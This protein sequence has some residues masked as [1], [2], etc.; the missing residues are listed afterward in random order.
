MQLIYV[1]ILMW[2]KNALVKKKKDN[3]SFWKWKM[4][5]WLV[6]KIFFLL[7]I[8][9]L[10]NQTQIINITFKFLSYSIV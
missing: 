9:H 3:L 1:F 10:L 7:P 8:L 4:G 2:V 6:W 5:L